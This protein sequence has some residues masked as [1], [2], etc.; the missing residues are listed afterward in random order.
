MGKRIE[1]DD[2]YSLY[3]NPFPTTEIVRLKV[4]S[5]DLGPTDVCFRGPH[6]MLESETFFDSGRGKQGNQSR[7]YYIVID[8]INHT[9][10]NKNLKVLK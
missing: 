4:G 1:S 2:H 3:G 10:N 7:M 6:K 5:P 9:L 8:I